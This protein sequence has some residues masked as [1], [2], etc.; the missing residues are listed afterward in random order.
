MMKMS[1]R[2]SNLKI[3]FLGNS[4]PRRCGIAT[5]T[6]DIETSVSNSLN[7]ETVT[8]AMTDFPA[9]YNYP[10]KVQ[11]EIH[12]DEIS[13]YLE[14]AKFI[15]FGG[16]DVLSLQHEFGIFG[17]E[18]GENILKLLENV[19]IPI[20][21]TLHT[22]LEHPS[23][24]QFE[25][26]TSIINHSS[27]L[28]VM[29]YK[30][31]ELLESIYKVPSEKIEVI[32]HGIPD[33]EFLDPDLAKSDI[34]FA[35]KTIILT[36][37]LLSRSKGIDLVIEAMPKILL[38]CPD[39]I[40][41]VL[42]ATHPNLVKS[43]GEKYRNKLKKQ[44]KQLGVEKQVFFIDDFVSLEDLVKYLSACDVYVTPYLNEDQMTSGTLAYSFGLG[45]VVIST[46]YWH[47]NELLKD[48]RG[49][50]VPFNDSKAIGEK[51]SHMLQ[52]HELRNKI[53]K[54]AFIA[55]REMIWP[56]IAQDYIKV[57]KNAIN[58]SKI[59]DYSLYQ[60][61]SEVSLLPIITDYFDS[62]CD[63]TGI[64]Q[65]AIYQVPD[66]HHGYC[67]DD[68]ARAL[69]LSCRMSA[70]QVAP[71]KNSIIFAAFI[72]HAW[73]NDNGRFRN[74]MSFGRD[75]LE[76]QGSEDSHGRTLWALGNC[77]RD[78][79]DENQRN[80]AKALFKNAYKSTISFTSPRAVAFAILGFEANP[81]DKNFA[82][83]LASR[84]YYHLEN[85]SSEDWY[86]FEHGLSYENARMPQALIIAGKI[87]NDDKFIKAGLRT[88]KFIMNAQTSKNNYFRPYATEG[89]FETGMSDKKFDQQP[90]EA[91]ASISACLTAYQIT[92]NDIWYLEAKKAYNW[93]SGKNDL[94]VSLIDP[95]TGSC[96]DGLHH[97]RVNE[98][99]GAESV[100]AYLLSQCDMNIFAQ[101]MPK[102]WKKENFDSIKHIKSARPIIIAGSN[103]GNST[104]V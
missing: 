55:G 22:I 52:D 38:D 20:V 104:P 95:I 18:A 85:N 83:I 33:L 26:L 8:I 103:A 17:G 86:W 50:I 19:R 9:N 90:V 48:G 69:L 64:T 99:C 24:K 66:R 65:H 76:A 75:W 43:E 44:A 4:L 31:K 30:G 60:N 46:P 91:Q 6:N 51:I 37:G 10:E 81:I 32:P 96:F 98:N 100:L 101:L 29:A 102:A 92:R 23:K 87:L 56:C 12:D 97:D 21:T 47:A 61:E 93:F 78:G 49:I 62:M 1:N 35:G 80:W 45:N 42:G 88:L 79:K 84:L 39:S 41:I 82:R 74:F 16:F 63:D 11:Y 3:A 27:K 59:I 25:V 36:F 71:L 14:A 57:F 94:G 54:T 72:Q 34:G 40:Y 89:F 68:N 73:N 15:K 28:I 67:V 70:A 13:D 58:S 77:V 5:F 53:R 7:V 2:K